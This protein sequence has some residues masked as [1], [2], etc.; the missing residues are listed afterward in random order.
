MLTALFA[1]GKQN[2]GFFALGEHGFEEGADYSIFQSF[3]VSRL[4]WAYSDATT[5]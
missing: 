3:V 4:V 1:D 5:T 2:V